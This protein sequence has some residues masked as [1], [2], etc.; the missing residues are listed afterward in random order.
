MNITAIT[1]TL[2][3]SLVLPAALVATAFALILAA[4]VLRRD[5][6]SKAMQEV[7]AMIFEGAVA[8]MRRQYVTIA[9]LALVM[10]V[11]IGALLAAFETPAVADTSVYGVDLGIKTGIAFLFGAVCSM[12]SGIIGMYISVK[13]NLRT[14]AAARFG[15]VKA[16]QVAMRGGA[17]S[18][19]LVA[20]LSL[21]RKS[22]RLNSS[23]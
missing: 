16:V 6:G 13:A 11:L 17:V 15:V 8:F 4:D 1:S 12:A 23:H 21:D 9:I 20:A 5:I 2:L 14:A 10:S 3:Q 18:G 22:T 7:S 19:F